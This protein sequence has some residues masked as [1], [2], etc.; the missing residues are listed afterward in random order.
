MIER[1]EVTTIQTFFLLHV[2]MS[3]FISS[4]LITFFKTDVVISCLASRSGTKSDSYKID[5]QVC[6]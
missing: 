6:F 3:T 4:V 2:R 5:Y 1:C